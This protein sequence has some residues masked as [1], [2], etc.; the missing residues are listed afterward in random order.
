MAKKGLNKAERAKR[1]KDAAMEL[2][3]PNG[4]KELKRPNK[5]DKPEKP[6]GSGPDPCWLGSNFTAIIPCLKR[7]RF[8]N[9][10][11]EGSWQKVVT[12]GGRVK[13]NK[14]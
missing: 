12:L 10:Q 9:Q 7:N 14:S 1:A 8:A 13:L 11:R 6:D 3:E 5:P 2:I 4:R